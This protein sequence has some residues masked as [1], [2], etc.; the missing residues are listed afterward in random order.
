[1]ILLVDDDPRILS[2]SAQILTAAGHH[3]FPALNGMAA[4][5]ILSAEPGIT[6]LVTDVLMPGMGG[7]ELVSRAKMIRAD[8]HI[9][10]VSGDIGSTPEAEFLGYERLTKPF[11]AAEL[12]AAIGRAEI[13]T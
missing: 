6:M 12:I 5:N 2:G 1:M 13:L 4:L 8:L 11:T 9:L 10:F 3:V 7:T